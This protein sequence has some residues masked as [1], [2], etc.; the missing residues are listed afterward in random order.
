[1]ILIVIVQARVFVI[2]QWHAIIAHAYVMLNTS[3]LVF[4]IPMIYLEKQWMTSVLIQFEYVIQ[5]KPLTFEIP[6]PYETKPSEQGF[7]HIR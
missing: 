5:R 7:R 2:T 4:L 3:Y 6:S 1:M